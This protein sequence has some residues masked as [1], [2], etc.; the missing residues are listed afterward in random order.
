MT[1]ITLDQHE[2]VRALKRVVLEV[3]DLIGVLGTGTIL[4]YET[5]YNAAHDLKLWAELVGESLL[6]RQEKSRSRSE[7]K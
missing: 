4:E 3:E 1:V 7:E 2:R 5:V 6:A